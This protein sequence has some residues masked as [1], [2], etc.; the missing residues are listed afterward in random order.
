MTAAAF[1]FDF[2]QEQ[3]RE[4]GGLRGFL[5]FQPLRGLMQLWGDAKRQE[6]AKRRGNAK[7]QE[8]AKGGGMRKGKRMRKGGAMR[9]R[10]AMRKCGKWEKGGKICQGTGQGDQSCYNMRTRIHVRKEGSGTEASGS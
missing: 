2:R 4:R 8:N 9:K 3:Y 7:R 10:W 5:F 6:N 1:I